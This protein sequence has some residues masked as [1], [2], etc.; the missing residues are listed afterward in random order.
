M[1]VA[2]VG[3][4]QVVVDSARRKAETPESKSRVS[5]D[6]EFEGVPVHIIEEDNAYKVNKSILKG[7]FKWMSLFLYKKRKENKVG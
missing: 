3:D 1:K 2:L 6:Y 5:N 4:F 7:S